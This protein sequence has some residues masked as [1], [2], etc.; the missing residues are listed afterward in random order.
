MFVKSL[1]VTF[2][3]LRQHIDPS[4]EDEHHELSKFKSDANQLGSSS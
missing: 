1:Q 3:G 2:D 4:D